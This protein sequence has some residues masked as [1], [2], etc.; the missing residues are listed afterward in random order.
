MNIQLFVEKNA[1]EPEQFGTCQI[2][3]EC[4]A[5]LFRSQHPIIANN[6][7]SLS[8]VKPLTDGRDVGIRRFAELWEYYR[9]LSL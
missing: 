4:N 9:R 8:R 7:T 6:R 1:F 2:S 3:S 5:A